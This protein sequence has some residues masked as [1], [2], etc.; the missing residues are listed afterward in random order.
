MSKSDF[1]FKQSSNNK[2]SRQG[3][4]IDNPSFI[5][6][7]SLR[8]DYPDI[9]M[10]QQFLLNKYDPIGEDLDN[11]EQNTKMSLYEVDEM[12][13]DSQDQDEG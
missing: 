2:Q 11:E 12:N 3:P 6:T 10:D 1:N 13:N 7:N 8:N 4:S 5:I 9:T